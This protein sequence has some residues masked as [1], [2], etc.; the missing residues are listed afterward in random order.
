M[1]SIFSFI[2]KS[3]YSQSESIHTTSGNSQSSSSGN[4]N[5]S[6]SL[7]SSAWSSESQFDRAEADNFSLGWYDEKK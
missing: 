3:G 4:S 6:R 1:D 2:V 7:V 5:S